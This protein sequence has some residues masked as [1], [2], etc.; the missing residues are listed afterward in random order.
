M[1]TSK[2]RGRAHVLTTVLGLI[3]IP[4]F[5]TSPA[6]AEE[7]PPEEPIEEIVV[8]GQ[9]SGPQG[10]FVATPDRATPNDPDTT[11]L[12]QLI[13]GGNVVSN[14][15]LTGQVQYRGMFGDRINV[16][17]GDM[18]VSPG[19]PNWMDAPLHYAPRPILDHLEMDLGIASVSS[20]SESIGGSA[21]AML[22]S[23]E[24]RSDED[25]VFDGDVEL[26][27]RTSDESLVGG[28]ILSAANERHRLHFLGSAEFGDDHRVGNGGRVRP[29]EYAR[30]QYGGGYGFKSG[31]HEIGLDYRYND[32]KK[33]GT[34]ALPMDIRSID[35]HLAK[36]DYA[37]K[38]GSVDLDA[39]ISFNDVEHTMDNFRLREPPAAGSSAWRKNRATSQGGG[40]SLA[41]DLS[42]LDGTLELGVDG[43]L[44]D[45]DARITNPNAASFF[46]TQFNNAR[47]NRYGTWVEWTG[48]I[49]QRW[50]LELGLRY[51]RVSMDSGKVDGTPAQMMAPIMALRDAFNA[52]DRE[53]SDD[54][55]D[56]VVK[57]GFTPRSGLRVELAGGRKTR[58]PSY[59]ERYAWIPTAA[60][61]GLADGKVYV[62]DIDLDPEVAYEIAGEVEWT[63]AL[64]VYL[65]P[66]AFYRYIDD[67]IQGTPFPAAGVTPVP[68]RFSNVDAELF[69]VDLAYGAHLPW[70]FKLDGTLSY[71][72]GKRTDIDDDL[73]RIAPLRGRTTLTYEREIWSI[74]VESVY[75][76]SQ[77]N[78]SETND[79]S[80]SD[81][82]GILNI[83]ASWDPIAELGFVAGVNNATDNGYSDHLA[84]TSR[85]S[86]GGVGVGDPLPA[87]GVSF[88][89]RTV[90]RF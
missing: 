4:I 34:P 62:G 83:Y 87:S 81:A 26:G 11:Q 73:Y 50:D 35:T 33:S 77:H 18:F 61:S 1:S 47:R 69:G 90:G 80:S 59:V 43:H 28:G 57:L 39:V 22:K 51:T 41:A 16:Q 85:I 15:P 40:W 52:A 72:R 44:S 13:P 63:S 75:A 29:S 3:A 24:F 76:A 19:G 20:G 55:V 31:D 8:K 42:V 64:G 49:G 9:K 12:L 25:F 5:I 67:Y 46:V 65:A 54:L 37:G 70:R 66:R 7:P 71:V 68:L 6:G 17:V 14:G 56:A 84:G 36:I 48:E 38:I 53:R 27:G 88:F 74:A 10:T 79:E 82:W 78:V 32:T 89:F 2:S 58:S 21:R 86:S 23:S 60:S 45:H 30:Y